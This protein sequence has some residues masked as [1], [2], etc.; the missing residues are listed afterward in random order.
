MFLKRNV[1][2][3]K[4]PF[5]DHKMHNIVN[6]FSSK[7]VIYYNIRSELIVLSFVIELL[8]ELVIFRPGYNLKETILGVM[9]LT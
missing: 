3:I 7:L 1:L 6:K 4:Y 2:A 9:Y 8:F 5:K